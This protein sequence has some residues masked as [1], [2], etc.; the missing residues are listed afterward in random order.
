MS[1]PPNG[2]HSK[3]SPTKHDLKPDAVAISTNSRLRFCSD[4]I[5]R[6]GSRGDDNLTAIAEHY[7]A[8]LR[9]L[10][11]DPD[12]EGLL[13]TPM[14]AAKAMLFFTKGYD[15]SIENAVKKVSVKT[16]LQSRFQ[17]LHMSLY[18]PHFR[19]F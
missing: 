17:D 11:E 4:S 18:R 19:S 3:M 5:S 2:S 15:D 13:D 12:R 9:L 7:K 16:F 14:R 8:I 6:E 1:I 10:G